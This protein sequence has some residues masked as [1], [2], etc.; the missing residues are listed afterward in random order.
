MRSL[1]PSW[2][3]ALSLGL[4]SLLRPMN[5]WLGM[6]AQINLERKRA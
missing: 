4:D 5:G 2:A 1:V 6:F 3:S